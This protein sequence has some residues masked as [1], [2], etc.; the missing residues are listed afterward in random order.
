MISDATATILTSD[1]K[2]RIKLSP[3]S[4]VRTTVMS[5]KLLTPEDYRKLLKLSI[6]EIVQYLEE[7]SY[8][9][10][11]DEL[12]STENGTALIEH[13][14]QRNFW[15]TVDKL[16]RISDDT[17]RFFIDVYV[18]RNDIQNIKT[19]LRAKRGNE[20]INRIRNLLLP[21]T[22]S[23][24]D[25]LDLY[26]EPTVERIIEELTLP[27]LDN[28]MAVYREE[29]LE[30]LETAMTNGY[31]SLTHKIA[32]RIPDPEDRFRQYLLL[33]VDLLNILTVLKLKRRDASAAEVKPFLIDPYSDLP[34]ES[35]T[36]RHR[37]RKQ[38]FAKLI[39]AD[40]INETL[41]IL[42]TTRFAEII[43]PG[44]A[45]YRV[46][47]SLLEMEREMQTYLLRRAAT[48][49]HQRPLQP[50]AVLSFL[51]AKVI[52]T[53]NIMVLVKGKSLDVSPTFLEQELILKYS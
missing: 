41:E 27:F 32:R 10:E 33:E 20:P 31:F 35:Y 7:T 37:T 44:A 1:D 24:D 13:A 15:R 3:Y 14:T 47:E 9:T 53:R 51:F 39:E 34:A 28:P 22:I 4:Y 23:K 45:A 48:I 50:D 46:S 49:S 17:L 36:I 6:P 18:W 30:G 8:H 26:S 11:I 42:E 38:L 43:A 19:L 29:G 40:G 16:R 52:E 21:G 2:I 12:A 5:S 25:L